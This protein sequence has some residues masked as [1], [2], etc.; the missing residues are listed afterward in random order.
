MGRGGL[1]WQPVQVDR[2]LG[3]RAQDSESD[4]PGVKS[5]LCPLA[6]DWFVHEPSWGSTHDCF[7]DIKV[8]VA[9]DAVTGTP[10]T[11]PLLSML[12]LVVSSRNAK[13][14]LCFLGLLSLVIF[15]VE[16]D[17]N[18]VS[19]IVPLC[20]KASPAFLLLPTACPP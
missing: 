2:G 7:Q 20:P 4:G 11:E 18:T 3:E 14:K 10:S 19:S 13:C 8:H 17:F 5:Q 6:L 9:S 12:A 1:I 16:T 15:D